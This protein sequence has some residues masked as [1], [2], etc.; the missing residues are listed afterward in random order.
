MERHL[1]AV[2]SKIAHLFRAVVSFVIHG[3][4]PSALAHSHPI[5]R[6]GR[7][8]LILKLGS[9]PRPSTVARS[10]QIRLY[11]STQLCDG[12]EVGWRAVMVRAVRVSELL[13]AAVVPGSGGRGLE[14][15]SK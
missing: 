2:G 11:R 7:F 6:T 14:F 4:G 3:I 12:G 5:A 1:N 9:D 15:F 13:T 8:T 10:T